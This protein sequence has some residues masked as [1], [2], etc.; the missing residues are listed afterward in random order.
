[1]YIDRPLGMQINCQFNWM[2]ITVGT[3]W[4]FHLKQLRNATKFIKNVVYKPQNLIESVTSA[5][6]RGTVPIDSNSQAD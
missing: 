1:M 2:L 5:T 4:V 3:K 6:G